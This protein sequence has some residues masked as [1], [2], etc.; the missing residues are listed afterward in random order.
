MTSR[1]IGSWNR[2]LVTLW[3]VA[4]FVQGGLASLD[5]SPTYDEPYHIIAGLSYVTAGRVVVNPQHPPL[6]KELAGLSMYAAGVRWP[7]DA[8]SVDALLG[9]DGANRVGNAL[10]AA[11]GP[12][13]VL[14][15]ARLPL[16]LLGTGLI[17]VIYALGRQWFGEHVGLAAA[18]WCAF[19]PTVLGH[20][21][22]V[23]TD[24]GM[25]FFVV[26]FLLALWFQLQRPT[27]WRLIFCGLAL[28]LLLGTK[29]SAVIILPVSAVVLGA[30]ALWPI[31][32]EHRGLGT[33]LLRHGAE[34]IGMVAIAGV[35]LQYVYL[36]PR[37]PL[38]YLEGMRLVNADHNRAWLYYL[39]GRFAHRFHG[40]FAVAY[41]VKQPLASIA[42]TVLGAA[43]LFR[44]GTCAPLVRI[45]LLL[46]L[47]GLFVG[48]TLFSDALGVRYII[49]ILPFTHLLAGLALATL[50][51]GN[52]LKRVLAG[53][54]AGWA[55]LTSLAIYPDHLSYFNEVACLAD[56]PDRLGLDGGSRC[57]PAWL[58][59]SNV[60][61]G[62]G[63]KAL[64]RWLDQYAAGRRV[65]VAYFG[66]FPPE[67]YGIPVGANDYVD[68]LRGIEPGLYAVSSHIVARA[69]EGA[70]QGGWM[71]DAAP[72][73]V[74]GHAF[75]IYEI[76]ARTAP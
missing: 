35:V 5:K 37:S 56:R 43:L 75:Y 30:A 66:V 42:A 20:A 4:F 9:G 34:W 22:L 32:P 60:D 71:V 48:Y 1:P 62:Q 61:W 19:D 10:I 40:Y 8:P 33:R 28:G 17:V 74:V 6:L 16:L 25:A 31:G 45:A 3:A 41:L 59:D 13:R 36:F 39:A 21:A 44:R 53:L 55:V 7:A 63:L 38:E 69:R 70:E 73:A 27:L 12:E 76:P 65:R 64:K 58:D 2:I 54:L 49:P 46:P 51:H 72:L 50:L 15:W 52:R 18:F 29:F 67:G 23:T 57:G 68:T 47:G 24:V 11:H 26:T 14:F